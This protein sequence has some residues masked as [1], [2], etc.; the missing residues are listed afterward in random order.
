MSVNSGDL[1]VLR[2]SMWSSYGREDDL[3]LVLETLIPQTGNDKET[4][5]RVLWSEDGQ[6]KIYKTEHLE[7]ISAS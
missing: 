4:F 1:V 2:G 3:G 5:S 6:A 7:V